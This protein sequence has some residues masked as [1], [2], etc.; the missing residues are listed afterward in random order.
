M[1]RD[2]PFVA[3]S[4][5]GA[6]CVRSNELRNGDGVN[7]SC[8]AHTHPHPHTHISADGRTNALRRDTH[9]L[10]RSHDQDNDSKR[11]RRA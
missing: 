3:E 4:D 11:A 2:T 7:P 5:T 9:T 8:D 6:L 10:W 1:H